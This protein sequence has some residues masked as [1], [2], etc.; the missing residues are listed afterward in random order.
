VRATVFSMRGQADALGQMIGG[1]I[2]GLVA[3]VFSLRAVMV[4]AGLMIAPALWLYRRSLRHA[5]AVDLG[6]ETPPA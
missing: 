5:P 6:I 1:P 2:V 3:T 4:L